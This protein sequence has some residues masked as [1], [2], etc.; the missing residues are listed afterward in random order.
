MKMAEVSDIVME[1]KG[2]NSEFVPSDGTKISQI[3]DLLV[4][5][6]IVM[7]ASRAI[8]VGKGLPKVSFLTTRDPSLELSYKSVMPMRFNEIIGERGRSRFVLDDF[9][10]GETTLDDVLKYAIDFV[11]RTVTDSFVYI[12][13][14]D[15]RNFSGVRVIPHERIGIPDE[16]IKSYTLDTKSADRVYLIGELQKVSGFDV[17]GFL[18][19]R[20]SALSS[21]LVIESFTNIRIGDLNRILRNSGSAPLPDRPSDFG[22]T[23]LPYSDPL[24]LSGILGQIGIL[25]SL[26][27]T[28]IVALCPTIRYEPLSPTDLR[29]TL[30]SSITTISL[31]S[32][33]E[34]VSP[35]IETDNDLQK[36]IL[37]LFC[38]GMIRIRIEF[39]EK[40]PSYV[41]AIAAL[42]SKLMFPYSAVNPH[43]SLITRDT[44][45]EVDGV[46]FQYLQQQPSFIFNDRGFDGLANLDG[47]KGDITAALREL[48]TDDRGQGWA[49]SGQ[50]LRANVPCVSSEVYQVESNPVY[51]AGNTN[52]NLIDDVTRTTRV[53]RSA[54]WRTAQA[55][56]LI[57]GYMGGRS[58]E[59]PNATVLMK[60]FCTEQLKFFCRLNDYNMFNY[61]TGFRFSLDELRN[62][63]ARDDLRREIPEFTIGI[64]S[65]LLWMKCN[66]SDEPFVRKMSW[67]DQFCMEGSMVKDLGRCLS[68]FHSGMEF[69]GR[70]D[71]L[72]C[73]WTPQKIRSMALGEC[74]GLGTYLSQIV[75]MDLKVTLSVDD[76][77]ACGVFPNISSQVT[78]LAVT[79]PCYMHIS[80]RLLISRDRLI[81]NIPDYLKRGEKD[82]IILQNVCS[83]EQEL[84]AERYSVS[85]M[86]ND[87]RQYRFRCQIATRLDTGVV[88][89]IPVRYGLEISESFTSSELP[90]TVSYGDI[91]Q[92][93]CRFLRLLPVSL[94]VVKYN[95]RVAIEN[96]LLVSS[97]SPTEAYYLVDADE[98]FT[99]SDLVDR[100]FIGSVISLGN[101]E[102]FSSYFKP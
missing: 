51:I 40:L 8:A 81:V 34:T 79:N 19:D 95:R 78:E 32:Y 101:G 76:I 56:S 86:V 52:F 18:T 83:H 73:F 28:G 74:G 48:T 60:R 44:A 85:D 75:S 14:E 37:A 15:R 45:E 58:S 27:L 67:L 91:L 92:D 87:S 66:K 12:S 46:I 70:W 98:V 7:H 30:S 33:L 41:H 93:P 43:E 6:D 65:I 21:R 42:F 20:L 38:P 39:D 64:R 24:L 77:A 53:A 89:P 3:L 1:A 57:A 11:E 59:N 63:H 47:R 25:F 55:V 100:R 94:R 84:R 35:N 13:R 26:R 97:L 23:F 5:A 61:G 62:I 10:S 69:A 96:D 50:Q 102:G 72:G 49:N 68:R 29:V 22:K 54:G 88:L 71:P 31:W 82:P 99:S 9:P 36:Y 80:P 17:S 2:G 16:L 90:I 4:H